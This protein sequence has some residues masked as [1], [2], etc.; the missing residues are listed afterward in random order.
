MTGCTGVVLALLMLSVACVAPSA[1]PAADSATPAVVSGNDAGEGDAGQGAI[2]VPDAGNPQTFALTIT[3]I[4]SGRV[5]SGSLF[6]CTRSCAVEVPAGTTFWADVESAQGFEF[7]RWDGACTGLVQC[8]VTVAGDVRLDATFTQIPLREINV[9]LA[10]DAPG[11]VVSTPSG[12]DCPGTCAAAF[13]GRF[14][15]VLSPAPGPAAVF[16]GWSRGC[17]GF[18]N[19]SVAPGPDLETRA[20][21]TLEDP[22]PAPPSVECDRLMPTAVTM[23]QHSSGFQYGRCGSAIGD[24][25]GDLAFL[26]YTDCTGY[27]DCNGHLDVVSADGSTGAEQRVSD[28]T[29]L[30]QQPRGFVLLEQPFGHGNPPPAVWAAALDGRGVS[31][32]MSEAIGAG[33]FFAAADPQGGVVIAGRLDA[34]D[35]RNPLGPPSGA[36]FASDGAVLWGPAM[37]ASAGAVYGVG[38]DLNGRTLVVSDGTSGFG[39]GSISGQWFDDGGSALT[40]EFLLLSGFV[41]EKSTRFELAPLIGGGLAIERRDEIVPEA[42]AAEVWILTIDSGG[43]VAQPAPRWLIERPE[44]H[45]AIARGGQA[46][47]LLSVGLMNTPCTQAVEVVTRDGQSCGQVLYSPRYLGVCPETQD[48]VLTADGTIVQKLPEDMDPTSSSGM[49]RCTWRYWPAA[50][51]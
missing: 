36:K 12:I 29:T 22:R 5:H 30:F 45:L 49:S 6:D 25:S 13:D 40:G 50:L 19:C 51:R 28:G 42:A 43:T 32:G 14:Q 7:T 4:G 37:L 18:A 8:R 20:T 47:A 26:R 38:V 27:G 17:S 11:R 34:A 16:S 31:L 10:G 48:L 9:T 35:I 39:P 46:Y 3:L 44:T 21:F 23:Q 41:A 33:G 2:D 24:A 15:V 1:P